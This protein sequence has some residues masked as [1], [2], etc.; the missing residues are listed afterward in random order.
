MQLLRQ[1]IRYTNVNR[2][3]RRPSSSN[4][5]LVLRPALYAKLQRRSFLAANSA[6]HALC[7]IRQQVTGN[8]VTGRR[9]MQH[10]VCREAN[11]NLPLCT[12]RVHLSATALAK[13]SQQTAQHSRRSRRYA[14]RIICTGLLYSL[15]QKVSCFSFVC[16]LLVLRFVMY[17]ESRG[18]ILRC[19]EKTM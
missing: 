15:S 2:T 10:C 1:L 19:T 5:S 4:L 3:W 11:N 13:L 17:C 14:D 18:N 6:K 9:T 7:E 8:L 12:R 16:F